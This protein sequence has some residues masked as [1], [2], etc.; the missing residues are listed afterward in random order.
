MKFNIRLLYLYLFSFVGLLITI[1]G[2][3]N[4]VSL[5]LKV[6]VFD[7]ADVQDYQDI[8]P[9][10]ARVSEG[11]E[12]PPQPEISEEDKQAIIHREAKKRRQREVSNSLSMIIVGIPLYFYHWNTIKKEKI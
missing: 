12:L 9:V 5:G 6:Y 4:L 10:P 2:S 1:I 8:K 7:N 11:M 3:T